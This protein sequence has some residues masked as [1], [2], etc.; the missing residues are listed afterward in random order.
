MQKKLITI[1]KVHIA[2]IIILLMGI[3]FLVDG[4]MRC[5]SLQNARTLKDINVKNV[6]SGIYIQDEVETVAGV[7]YNQNGATGFLGA[8]MQYQDLFMRNYTFYTIPISYDGLEY[9]TVIVPEKEDDLWKTLSNIKTEHKVAL[10]GRT[11]KMQ[12]SPNYELLLAAT[13]TKSEMDLLSQFSDQYAI[14]LVDPYRENL[15][16]IKG[17]SMIVTSILLWIV[18]DWRRGSLTIQLKGK[19]NGNKA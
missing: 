15:I 1:S 16:W 4:I 18:A 5:Y 12:I 10:V 6:R 2:S 17:F 14:M 11:V 13:N 19:K 7:Y 9:L 8:T 3:L